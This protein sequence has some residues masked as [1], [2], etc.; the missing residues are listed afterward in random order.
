MGNNES[1]TPR[2]SASHSLANPG[3]N[4]CCR[5]AR[6][7][8]SSH[9]SLT[10]PSAAAKAGVCGV[11]Q[12][13]WPGIQDAFLPSHSREPGPEGRAVPLSP[14]PPLSRR[15]RRQRSELKLRK[16]AVD[17]VDKLQMA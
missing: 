10:P 4:R 2:V 3:I 6:I 9:A 16:E 7:R 13:R 14:L 15:M 1:Q 8:Q 11:T 5:L 17:W 12:G